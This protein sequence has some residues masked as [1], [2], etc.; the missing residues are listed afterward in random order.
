ML[1]CSFADLHLLINFLRKLNVFE[2][3]T[4]IVLGLSAARD[5]GSTGIACSLCAIVSLGKV[6][7]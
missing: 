4:L 3:E 2:I 5:S 7:P 6:A 1:E